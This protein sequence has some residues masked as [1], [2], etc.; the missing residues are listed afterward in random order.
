MTAISCSGPTDTGK[1]FTRRHH[2]QTSTR[3]FTNASRI[4][5]PSY[6]LWKSEMSSLPAERTRPG[7]NESEPSMGTD[8]LNGML[9]VPDRE[10][11]HEMKSSVPHRWTSGMDFIPESV[12]DDSLTESI[13]NLNGARENYSASRAI[14]VGSVTNITTSNNGNNVT[15]VSTTES[16]PKPTLTPS[17]LQ[18]TN[19]I[20]PVSCTNADEMGTKRKASYG[21]RDI[22]GDGLNEKCKKRVILNP[23]DSPSHT[24]E[25]DL[26][27]TNR[28]VESPLGDHMNNGAEEGYPRCDNDNDT[29]DTNNG[30]T[31]P[32]QQNLML[33]KFY[34]AWFDAIHQSANTAPVGLG[35]TNSP[36][37]AA[38]TT[39]IT[40]SATFGP[41]PH[42][43]ASTP[44]QNHPQQTTS[45]ALPGSNQCG[46]GTFVTSVM[47]N[48]VSTTHSDLGNDSGTSIGGALSSLYWLGLFPGCTDP[49][50]NL[51]SVSSNCPLPGLPSYKDEG[52][53]MVGTKNDLTRSD[54]FLAAIAAAATAGAYLKPPPMGNV[55]Q[56]LS[57]N[58]LVGL[59][60]PGFDSAHFFE[61][62]LSRDP[63]FVGMESNSD[64]LLPN[65]ALNNSSGPPHVYPFTEP[66][67]LVTQAALMTRGIN[68]PAA[69]GAA[70]AAAAGMGM[71]NRTTGEFPF[72]PGAIKYSER[73]LLL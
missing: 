32:N 36:N 35:T 8:T 17:R 40:S 67:G 18:L 10:V 12:R 3:V 46:S 73:F 53:S 4:S 49:S 2:P 29:T 37:T 69:I 39:T 68:N 9:T 13:L 24:S 38:V 20:F 57:S 14:T 19:G 54:Q 45:N 43:A 30:N 5:S 7:S 52:N 27:Q 11:S 21:I 31:N 58:L 64:T 61:S 16:A 62:S 25:L 47:N 70:A 15:V 41:S 65:P 28:Q 66:P 23:T 44:G 33:M 42:L 1:F 34:A 60:H 22:L 6:P 71:W 50:L 59:P 48:A 72:L 55:T 26:A 63:R 56:S 51:S